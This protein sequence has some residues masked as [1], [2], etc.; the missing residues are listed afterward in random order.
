MHQ[1][2][3][4]RTE[5]DLKVNPNLTTKRFIIGPLRARGFDAHSTGGLVQGGGGVTREE[6]A[7]FG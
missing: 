2:V 6:S 7:F 5:A 1:N 3:T 4:L